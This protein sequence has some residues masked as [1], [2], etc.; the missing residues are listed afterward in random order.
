MKTLK[1][2]KEQKDLKENINQN[3]EFICDEINKGE[4]FP[5]NLYGYKIECDCEYSF[6]MVYGDKERD[7]VVSEFKEICSVCNKEFRVSENRIPTDTAMMLFL[8]KPDDDKIPAMMF[9]SCTPEIIEQFYL[10]GE[11]LLKNKPWLLPTIQRK[12]DREKQRH[13]NIMEELKFMAKNNL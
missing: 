13:N 12:I 7:N 6:M 8:N 11:R 3:V 9:A 10:A 5:I 2:R 1:P 4:I